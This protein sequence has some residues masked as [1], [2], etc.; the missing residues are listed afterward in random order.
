[1]EKAVERRI[2]T[3]FTART[4]DRPTPKALWAA[5]TSQV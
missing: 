2:M 3:D 5:I 1:M 4:A